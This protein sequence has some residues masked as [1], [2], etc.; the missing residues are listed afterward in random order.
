MPVCCEGCDED[1][2]NFCCGNEITFADDNKDYTILRRIKVNINNSCIYQLK[3][4]DPTNPTQ[5]LQI[6]VTDENKMTKTTCLDVITKM[7]DN[8]PY[9]SNNKLKNY[10]INNVLGDI[11]EGE[12]SHNMSIKTTTN[13]IT[14]TIDGVEF[15][16]TN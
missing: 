6:N 14:L 16:K 1:G 3:A 15:K 12:C 5:L 8:L 2:F 11:C 4:C 13:S 10:L 7:W 9:E